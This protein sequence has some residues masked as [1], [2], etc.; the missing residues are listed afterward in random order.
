MTNWQEPEEFGPGGREI[1]SELL[2]EQDD[3]ST[4]ALVIEAARAKDRL[5]RLARI[6]TGDVDCW[7]RIFAGE[8]EGELV[9]KMDTAVSEQRQLATVL[10]QLLAEIQRRQSEQSDESEE[11]GLADL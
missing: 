4:K 3:V 2:S 6:T 10:R 5:D 11:D 7:T 9:L 8:L 1:V